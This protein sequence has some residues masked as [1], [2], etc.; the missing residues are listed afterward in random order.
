MRCCH[1]GFCGGVED[2]AHRE[3]FVMRIWSEQLGLVH[4]VG[5]HLPLASSRLRWRMSVGT[6]LRMV[7]P[8]PKI[9][10]CP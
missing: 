4:L 10:E 3:L 2:E 7:S 8:D 5:V 1:A 6:E 9:E